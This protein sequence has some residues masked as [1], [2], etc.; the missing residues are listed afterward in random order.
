MIG[1]SPNRWKL[2]AFGNP[3]LKALKG[4]F[5]PLCHEYDHITPYSKGGKTE[6]ENCQILQ[7]TLNK[8]K[9]DRIDIGFPE[10]RKISP[11]FDFSGTRIYI[12]VYFIFISYFFLKYLIFFCLL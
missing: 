6:V 3:V 2:D 5:G 10:M 1:R 9:S 11:I 4:C 8:V 12:I 7:T